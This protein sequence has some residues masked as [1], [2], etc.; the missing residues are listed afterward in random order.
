MSHQGLKDLIWIDC[1][2]EPIISGCYEVVTY[3][4]TRNEGWC[5]IEYTVTIYFNLDRKIFYKRIQDG[6]PGHGSVRWRY[7]QYE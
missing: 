6:Y 4:G 1:P 7:S 2:E 5:T 3:N